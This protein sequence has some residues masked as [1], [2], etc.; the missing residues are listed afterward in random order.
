MTLIVG[1]MGPGTEPGQPHLLKS[2]RPADND[3]HWHM[4]CSAEGYR[5]MSC[6]KPDRGNP[7]VRDYR[8]GGGNA[9]WLG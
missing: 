7:A 3:G 9:A 2:A 1:K 8:E 6:L 5:R 4:E